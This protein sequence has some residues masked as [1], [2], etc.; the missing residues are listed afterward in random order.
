MTEDAVFDRSEGMLNRRS[1]QPHRGW[2]RTSVHAVQRVVIDGARDDPPCRLGTESSARTS[3]TVLDGGFIADRSHRPVQLFPR[4]RL[5][6][7]AEEG[8]ARG[9]VV[10]GTPI[11]QVVCNGSERLEKCR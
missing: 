2:S 8:I 7:G 5:A 9:L 3:S 1:P 10:E 4:Q 6:F 11:K